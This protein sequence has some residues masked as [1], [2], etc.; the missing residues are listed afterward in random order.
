MAQTVTIE[1]SK[2]NQILKTLTEIKQ[3][4]AKLAEKVDSKEPAYGSD[5]WWEWSD[6]KAEKDIKAGNVMKF[7]S[8]KEAAEWLN[9]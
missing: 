3:E 4:V 9:S 1:E 2:L 6:K 5:E 8:A 7:K